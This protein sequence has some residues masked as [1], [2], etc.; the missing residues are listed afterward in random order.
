MMNSQSTMK[1]S[2]GKALAAGVAAVLTAFATVPASALPTGSVG[3]QRA[4]VAT[5]VENVRCGR[6]C[7]VGVGVAAGVVAGAA[8]AGAANRD[9]YYRDNYYY[10]EPG[11]V[12]YRG[13]AAPRYGRCWVEVNPNR[14]TGYWGRC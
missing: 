2:R 1:K 14:G 7:A 11:P 13:Y 8:I 9:R 4:P 5:P 6:G 10:D 3:F 12:Y